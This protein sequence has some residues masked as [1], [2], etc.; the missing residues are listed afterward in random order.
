LECGN[1]KIFSGIKEKQM[2]IV[3]LFCFANFLKQLRKKNVVFFPQKKEHNIY[4]QKYRKKR[5]CLTVSSKRKNNSQIILFRLLKNRFRKQEFLG[6]KCAKSVRSKLPQGGFVDTRFVV[7][8]TFCE[9]IVYFLNC[10]QENFTF[11]KKI[12]IWKKTKTNEK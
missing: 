11:V 9:Q 4:S 3:L 12:L 5:Q 7:R 2:K 1:D 6:K 8:K 10:F